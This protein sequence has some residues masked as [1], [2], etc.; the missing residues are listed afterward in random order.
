MRMRDHEARRREAWWRGVGWL[1]GVQAS[2]MRPAS[3]AMAMMRVTRRPKSRVTSGM[4]ATASATM[5][6]SAHGAGAAG[7]GP[8]RGLWRRGQPGRTRA[9]RAAAGWKQAARST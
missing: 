9:V 7:Q 5:S 4:S 8:R 2:V 3:A 1:S 6:V